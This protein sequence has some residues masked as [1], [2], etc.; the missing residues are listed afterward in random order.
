MS[1]QKKFTHFAH[2]IP[3]EDIRLS[4]LSFHKTVFVQRDVENLQSI[5]RKMRENR[6]SGAHE[7]DTSVPGD[8][9]YTNNI[10]QNL[11]LSRFDNP[12]LES[13]QDKYIW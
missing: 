1:T 3:Q 7:F 6:V 9:G 12:D 11:G 8:D 13:S 4:D 10:D 5:K 2:Y